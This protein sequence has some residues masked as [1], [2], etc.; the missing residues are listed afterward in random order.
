[1]DSG[2]VLTSAISVGAWFTTLKRH[3]AW[4]QHA[5]FKGEEDEGGRFTKVNS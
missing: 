5:N 4:A 3:A 2:G 1:M